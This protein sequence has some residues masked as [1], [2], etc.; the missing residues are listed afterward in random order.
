M[1]IGSTINEIT[2]KDVFSSEEWHDYYYCKTKNQVWRLLNTTNDRVN[3]RVVF[4][5]MGGNSFY[6]LFTTKAKLFA[7]QKKKTDS[8]KLYMAVL[9]HFPATG[10][11][12]SSS[13]VERII[14]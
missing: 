14:W 11:T 8:L 10:F 9:I 12:L 13:N 5:N 6:C 3:S 1:C 2:L 7:M 4:R